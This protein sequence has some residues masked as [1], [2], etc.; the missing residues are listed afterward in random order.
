M[1]KITTEEKQDIVL[2][3]IMERYEGLTDCI[4]Q[5]REDADVVYVNIADDINDVIEEDEIEEIIN[6]LVT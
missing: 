4:S 6:K 2:K 1:E 3:A 5:L